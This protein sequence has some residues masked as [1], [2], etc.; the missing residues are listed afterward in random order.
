MIALADPMWFGKRT[1]AFGK[2]ISSQ[3]LG[4]RFKDVRVRNIAH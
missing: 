2:G 3:I 4:T 1:N